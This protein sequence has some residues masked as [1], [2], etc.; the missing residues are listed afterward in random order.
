MADSYRLTVMKRLC[1]HLGQ[2]TV[3]N[4]FEFD[5]E[6]AI[7]RGR[8]AFGDSD[9]LPMLSIVEAQQP[10]VGLDVGT[11]NSER[12]TDWP[13]IVQGW[14]K[15]D[16]ENPSDP[17]YQLMA[18]VETQLYKII[19]TDK[20]T[21]DGKYPELY[22]LGSGGQRGKYLIADLRYGPGVVSPPRDQVSTQAFFFMPVIIRLAEKVGQPYFLL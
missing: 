13:L 16:K 18:A 20:N 5:L 22:L 12:R 9:R 7:Y 17:A 3:A 11:H 15:N 14:V 8:M 4:G 19:E 2:I 21:G 10:G 6:G 1:D